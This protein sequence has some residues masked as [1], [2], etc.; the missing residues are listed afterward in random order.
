MAPPEST[1]RRPAVLVI[2]VLG[3]L[4]FPAVSGQAMGNPGLE[5]SR[6]SGVI[7]L[8][9]D[10]G[11]HPM[12]TPM[13]LDLLERRGARATFFPLGRR[14]EERWETHQIQDLL[15][16][17]HALGNHSWNHPRLVEMGGRLANGLGEVAS[18]AGIPL[19]I[20]QIGSMLCLFFSEN[21]VKNYEQAVATETKRFKALFRHALA[22]GVYL[23]PS[24]FETCFLSVAHGDKEI[25]RAMEVLGEGIRSL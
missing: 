15:N 14:L 10:D 1:S 20:P 18:D 21:P 23:P 22:H 24:P 5:A 3:M 9:F 25:E 11:P 7:Y 6:D 2:L 13:I 19:Q 4:I 12:Y 17:G 16:R 8:T